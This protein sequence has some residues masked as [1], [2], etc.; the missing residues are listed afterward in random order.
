MLINHNQ[1]TLADEMIVQIT[2]LLLHWV[3]NEEITRDNIIQICEFIDKNQTMYKNQETNLKY[4]KLLEQL[5][6]YLDDNEL[7]NKLFNANNSNVIDKISKFSSNQSTD[8]FV[9]LLQD[10]MFCMWTGEFKQFYY[11]KL[12]P[13]DSEKLLRL[14]KEFNIIKKSIGISQEASIF[15][16]IEKNKLNKM[17]FIITGPTNTPYDQGL[18]IF[19][20]TL[21]KEFPNK[22]PQVHFSNNGG[23]R[24]NPNLYNCGKVCLSL[25]GTWN[26]DKGESW[27]SATSTFFQ[28]LISI[29]SQILIEEPYF[30][31]PG[32][33]SSI[34][35]PGGIF[36]SKKYN[37]HI[38]QYNLDYAING[39]IAGVVSGSSDYPEF[40][41]IIR[42]YFKFKKQRILNNLNKWEKEYTDGNLL[43]KFKKSKNRFIEL[44]EKL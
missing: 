22:P 28:I 15:F 41:N 27:N 16:W 7:T 18:Y 4:I 36:N 35:K 44:S 42:E 34:G 39:L 12:V 19:D 1:S 37:D 20:M 2:S 8:Q 17:R 5:K 29:Q 6:S 40:D 25:L 14:K 32:H 31:E 21:S 24:F 43:D 13:I 26:G 23:Q 38:K 30:N 11:E 3:M 33:E 10:K 9:S